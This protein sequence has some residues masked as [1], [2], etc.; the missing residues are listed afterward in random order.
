M[1]TK[2]PDSQS[3]C[4]GMTKYVEIT[5]TSKLY[6]RVVVLEELPCSVHVAPQP[7][8]KETAQ[9][10]SQTTSWSFREHQPQLRDIPGGDRSL[11]A[12]LIQHLLCW[13]RTKTQSHINWRCVSTVFQP[14]KWATNKLTAAHWNLPHNAA[15]FMQNLPSKHFSS[16]FSLFIIH[17][18][19]VSHMPRSVFL[20]A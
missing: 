2:L 16:V 12:C 1:L 5:I 8:E 13:A 15:Q 11:H 3:I 19:S 4:L 10:Q 9:T 18:V 6:T 20:E 7:Q 17:L 14:F